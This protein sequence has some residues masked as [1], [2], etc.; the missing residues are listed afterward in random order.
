MEVTL[1]NH[2]IPVTILLQQT[3]NGFIFL[4]KY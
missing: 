3:I 4:I 2:I 1:N